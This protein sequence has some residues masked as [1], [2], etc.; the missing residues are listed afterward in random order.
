MSN[1]SALVDAPD[2]YTPANSCRIHANVFIDR[3]QDTGAFSTWACQASLKE[4]KIKI[5]GTLRPDV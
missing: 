5:M 1:L 3:D 2:S 4:L